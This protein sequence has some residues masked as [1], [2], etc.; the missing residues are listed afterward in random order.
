[1]NPTK[2]LLSHNKWFTLK[3]KLTGIFVFLFFC[4]IFSLIIS[5]QYHIAQKA[6]D[7]EMS[8]ILQNIHKSIE[9]SLK[10][11]YVGALTL[12]LTIN[13][14]G[15]PENFEAVGKQILANDEYIDAVQLVPDGIIRYTYP[16]E[17]NE[18]AIGIN[19]LKDKKYRHEALKAIQTRKMYF[20]GPFE[21]KQGGLGILGRLAIYKNNKFWG[22]FGCH[23]SLRN[24]IE[25][26]RN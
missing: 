2:S 14:K 19:L 15:I 11:N 3:P 26:S 10:D 8:G 7:D 13:D 16:L 21:L 18:A 23:Y 4:I 1:M 12:A 5:Q 6:K 17:G 20:A 22:F 25:Q 9:Q 24:L